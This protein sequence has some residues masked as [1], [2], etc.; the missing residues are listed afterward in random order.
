MTMK[1]KRRMRMRSEFSICASVCAAACLLLS[2]CRQAEVSAAERA[3]RASRLYSAAMAELQAGRV[4]SAIEGFQSVIKSE[5]GNGNAHFQLAALLEDAKKDYLGAIIHYRLYCMIRPDSEK[6]VVA[7]DR[8]KGCEIRYAADALTKAGLESKLSEELET[9]RKEHR[10]CGKKM[11]KLADELAESQRKVAALENAGELKSRMLEKASAVN[12]DSNVA[13]APKKTL[14][15]TDAQ[16]LEDDD[17]GVRR[18]S[19]KEISDLRAMLDED[20][21]TAN[22][23]KVEKKDDAGKPSAG[24][25]LSGVFASDDEKKKEKK[26]RAKRDIP[27]TYTIEE[28]DTL[29]RISIKFYGTNRRWREIREANKTIISPDGRV[30]I[31][32]VIKLP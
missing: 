3:D 14:R 13:A 18:I 9:L 2:G 5:P 29:M 8:M 27:E 21:R 24:S 20:E 11:A 17:E 10:N 15:P 32:Q 1:K 25:P 22:P 6:A 31:G 12:D 16:L 7:T 19:S 23:P 28:G 30:R 26:K 4:D